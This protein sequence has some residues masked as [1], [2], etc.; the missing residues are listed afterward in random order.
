[1]SVKVGHVI[2]E[3]ILNNK[4]KQLPIANYSEL[5]NVDA[6]LLYF[7]LQKERIKVYERINRGEAVEN[8]CLLK[9]VDFLQFINF[10]GNNKIKNN[11]KIKDALDEYV[12]KR[13]FIE[14]I[15]YDRISYTYDIHFIPLSEEEKA[16][17]K[18]Y[19]NEIES[20]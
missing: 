5:S 6:K 15:E 9:Y 17:L 8:H 10:G 12:K 13:I 14:K 20:N 3:A 1:M 16:D 11:K 7:P 4:L 18:Y 19:Y 2:A